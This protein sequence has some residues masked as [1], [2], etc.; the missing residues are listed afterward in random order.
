MLKP[1]YVKLITA[2]CVVFALSV[3]A[4]GAR[5]EDPK[6]APA[7]LTVEQALNVAAGLAQLA[8]YDTVDKDGKPSKVYYKFSADLRILIAVNIDVGRAIQTRFQNASND[9]IMQL[10]DGSGTLPDE[11]KGAFNVE[12]A[13]L[14]QAQ[15]RA[16][17]TR[18]K[19]ADL[20]LDE[21]QV[22]A[23]VLS[24]IIPIL[25]R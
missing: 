14:M 16:G 25:D 7:G 12:I 5:A 24:L 11:K 9:L 8:S 23:P 10:S 20:K 17:Y 18:I 1:S 22:P 3:A 13:K 21:N 15:S 4:F 19:L 6:P 2:A